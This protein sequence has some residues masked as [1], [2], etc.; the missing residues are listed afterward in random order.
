MPQQYFQPSVQNGNVVVIHLKTSELINH[1]DKNADI[2][3]FVFKTWSESE[4]AS[5]L[6]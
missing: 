6:Y 5:E 4:C 3:E 1:V 2:E